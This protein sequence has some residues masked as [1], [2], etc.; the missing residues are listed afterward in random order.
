M[1]ESNVYPGRSNTLTCSKAV[2][3]E[4]VSKSMGANVRHP[5]RRREGKSTQ[6]YMVVP[7]QK[8]LDG[9]ATEEG[10]VRQFVS[11]PTTS[12]YSVEAQITGQSIMG[13]IQF[14]VTP[15]KPII[16]KTLCGSAE[17]PIA[18]KTLTGK[19][20]HLSVRG[21]QSV[22][23]VKEQIYFKEGIPPDQQRL[24]LSG[25]QLGKGK[26]YFLNIYSDRQ[27][28]VADN[29]RLEDYGICKVGGN[30]CNL[31][32][33]LNLQQDTVL[34][35]VLRLRGG[36][37]RPPPEEESTEM[38]IAAGGNITQ[39]I[40]AD[41]HGPGFWD[42]DGTVLFN[43][44]IVNAEESNH[45]TQSA[46]SKPR[47]PMTAQECAAKGIPFFKFSETEHTS[48]VSGD[49]GGVKSVVQLDNIK[50]GKGSRSDEEKSH[51]FPIVL[52][53]R[54]GHPLAFDP[55]S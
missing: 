11:V 8:W 24:I 18:V 42:V 38:S 15:Q 32:C 14:E 2:S 22:K 23:N 43:V 16:P 39:S 53:D 33:L 49:F 34:H 40:C 25:V 7:Q 13:G 54:E 46:G 51:K 27:L 30:L 37:F 17:Y 44:Q 20:I 10:R 47:T 35:L 48:S 52:M 31:V 1:V 41:P 36:G 26:L 19:T 29:A 3:G 4:P 28:K 6:D 21:D 9:I 5:E 50:G 55:V 12:G 45:I